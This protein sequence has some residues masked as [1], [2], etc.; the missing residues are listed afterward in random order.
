LA[1]PLARTH[2]VI[3]REQLTKCLHLT[4]VTTIDFFV[5]KRQRLQDLLCPPD[6]NGSKTVPGCRLLLFAFQSLLT[7]NFS[8]FDLTIDS[9][10]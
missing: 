3:R 10:K 4:G 2:V 9:L 5:A 1:P 8:M 6:A 7:S